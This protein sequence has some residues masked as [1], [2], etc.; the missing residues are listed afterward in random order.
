ATYILTIYGD[1]GSTGAYSFDLFNAALPITALTLGTPVAGTLAN[2]GDEAEYTF[3]ATA[4]ERL[5][6]NAT[7]NS[8]GIGA[9]LKGPSGE[10][11]FNINAAG[12]NG[13]YTVPEPGAYTLLIYGDDA[14]TGNYGFDL[15]QPALPVAPLTL[16]TTVAGTLA[17]A[18]D[19]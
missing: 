1:A 17:N 9:L 2:P 14:M 16:G 15:R 10:Q 7:V 8:S 6:Y 18:G 13:P 5:F 12:Q 11:L 3:T 4:G 19:E